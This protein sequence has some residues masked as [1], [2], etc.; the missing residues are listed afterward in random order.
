MQ[1]IVCPDSA[2]SAAP[3]FFLT[4]F[5]Q[6]EAVHLET[7]FGYRYDQRVWLFA[8]LVLGFLGE[9]CLTEGKQTGRKTTPAVW[10]VSSYWRVP[11]FLISSLSVASTC[12]R[13]TCSLAFN[14]TVVFRRPLY[15]SFVR[16]NPLPIVRR[17]DLGF[18]LSL[19]HVF[20][21]PGAS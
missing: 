20:S 4:L 3:L 8:I 1:C 15:T 10:A 6:L 14:C 13:A 11:V 5:Y 12:T 19:F 17:V 7:W 2:V 18:F 9:L 16:W 21:F